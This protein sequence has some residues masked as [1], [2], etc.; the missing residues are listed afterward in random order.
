M[1]VRPLALIVAIFGSAAA[2]AAFVVTQMPLEGQVSPPASTADALAPPVISPPLEPPATA[3]DGVVEVRVTAGGEPQRDAEVRLYAAPQEVGGPWRRAGSSRTDHAGVVRL[4]ARPGLFLASASAPGLARRV[5]EVVRGRGEESTRVDLALEPAVALDGR[6]SAPE[7]GPIAGARVTVVP[8]V[9]RSPGFATASAPPEETAVSDT[10]AAGAFRVAGLA[11]GSYAVS[12]AAPGRHPTL[13]PRVAVPGEALAITIAPLGAAEGVVL[14]PDGRPAAGAL[15]RA[16]SADH[17]A[18]AT[19]GAD[20][21]FLIAAPAGSYLVVASLGDRAGVSAEPVAVTAGASAR[22]ATIRLGP[23]AILGGTV[24]LAGGEP[25]AGARVALLGHGSREVLA[26]A[27][28]GAEGAFEVR[29]LAPTAYDVE[30]AAPGAS[31]ARLAGVTLAEGA[32]FP[33]RIALAGTGAVEGAVTDVAGRPLAGIRVR[34]LQ[35]GDGLPGPSPETRTGFDGR[36]RLDGLEVGRTEIVA[37]HPAALL[38]ASRAVRVS[39][40]RAAALDLVLPDAGVLAGRVSEEGRPPRAG[41]TVVAVP[42]SG[43]AG[44]LQVARAVAD[45][46]GNYALSLPAGEYRVHAAPGAAAAHGPPGR[47]GVRA[48]RGRAGDPAR[49]RARGHLARAGRRHPRARARRRAL[50]RRRR[51]ALPSGRRARRARDV[52]RRGRPRVDRPPDGDGRARGDHPRH[53]TVGA[54]APSPCALPEA[55]TVSMRLHPGGTV[56]GVVRGARSGFTLE[57][58]SQPASGRLAY[59]R[60]PPVRRRAVRARRPAPGAAPARR[61]LGRRS[62]R[63]RR[64]ARRPRRDARRRDRASARSDAPSAFTIAGSRSPALPRAKNPLGRCS[65]MSA[66]GFGSGFTSTMAAPRRQAS[67]PI[68]IGRFVAPLVP[69][70]RRRSAAPAAR[71]ADSIR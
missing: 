32:R 65:A 55:G 49:P 43:G 40:G 42:M 48:R 60:R 25:A 21:R 22:G 26:T 16:A 7:G 2:T 36:F 39:A 46:S 66:N 63:R 67:W 1:R 62:P 17:G 18:S 30:V 68:C 33:V 47:A 24:S 9:S 69:T 14:F 45:A 54:P 19:A 29:G 38:G 51:H 3:A 58:A 37:H 57:V 23:A 70:T 13:L 11:P 31:P 35:R 71:S 15:V 50:S 52:G 6:A 44:T 53:G 12:V 10:D 41:T 20:G 64:G 28:V 59:A 4:P 5:A 61:A 56:E 8:L 27:T 34:A